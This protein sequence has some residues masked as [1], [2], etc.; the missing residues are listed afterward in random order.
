VLV[1]ERDSRVLEVE[2]LVADDLEGDGAVV[3]AVAAENL[4]GLD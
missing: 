2:R 1:R 4:D 3:E